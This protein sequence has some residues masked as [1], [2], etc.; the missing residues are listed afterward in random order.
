MAWAGG[1]GP[2]AVTTLTAKGYKTG[3]GARRRSHIDPPNH[4]PASS[5]NYRHGAA[6]EIA[7]SYGDR[8]DFPREY[9][10][11]WLASRRHPYLTWCGTCRQSEEK[12][13][14][15]ELAISSLRAGP[16]FFVFNAAASPR[17]NWAIWCVAGAMGLIWWYF[18]RRRGGLGQPAGQP[19]DGAISQPGG[20]S[21]GN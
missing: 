7:R 16:L 11:R 12:T 8:C 4:P 13:G 20:S 5:R 21:R 18:R 14:G 19:V 6:V 2:A 1:D 3:R 17:E 15:R 10:W 9:Y